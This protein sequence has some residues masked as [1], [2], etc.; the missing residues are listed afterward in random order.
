ME[1]HP[2]EMNPRNGNYGGG[3]GDWFGYRDLLE[4]WQCCG[5]HRGAAKN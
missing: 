3:V 2:E 1:G 5:I 4:E